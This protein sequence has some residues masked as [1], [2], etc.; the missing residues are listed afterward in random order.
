M[1]AEP[2]VS[3]AF[4]LLFSLRVKAVNT[5]HKY[6]ECFLRNYKIFPY[7]GSR[8]TGEY[9]RDVVSRFTCIFDISEEPIFGA[10][11]LVVQLFL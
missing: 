6:T 4:A 9:P 10:Y 5:L 8:L 2:D 11:T 3:G 1:S 7:P